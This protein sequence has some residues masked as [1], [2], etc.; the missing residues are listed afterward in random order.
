MLPHNTGHHY[1][2]IMIMSSYKMKIRTTRKDIKPR[3]TGV[4]LVVLSGHF[5][6][7]TA[8]NSLKQH[9]KAAKIPNGDVQ[10]H[11]MFH[12]LTKT[13]DTQYVHELTKTPTVNLS[14]H[15]TYYRLNLSKY[16]TCYRLNLS[17]YCTC[18]RL[19]LSEYCTCHRLNLSEYCTCYC[20]T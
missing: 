12:E 20:L 11:N 4:S 8:G 13:P 16:C 10:R 1:E 3:Q 17:K 6:L 14:K 9:G 18:Y 19:N 7:P 5:H 2:C 15:C